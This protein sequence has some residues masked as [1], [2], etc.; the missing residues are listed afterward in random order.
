M[1]DS[2]DEDEVSIGTLKLLMNLLM[3]FQCNKLPISGAS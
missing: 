1:E 2:R 3:F